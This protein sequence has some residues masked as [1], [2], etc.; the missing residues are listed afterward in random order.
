MAPPVLHRSG[1]PASYETT[2]LKMR[3]ISDLLEAP[4]P[5]GDEGEIPL[6]LDAIE[7]LIHWEKSFYAEAIALQCAFWNHKIQ[8]HTEVEGIAPVVGL[9]VWR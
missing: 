4:L 8:T 2:K 5:T 6:E 1:P 3:K 7:I 9:E